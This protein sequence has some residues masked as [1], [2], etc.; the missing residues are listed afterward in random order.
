MPTA[1]KTALVVVALVVAYLAGGMS[2]STHLGSHFV[3]SYAMHPALL[4]VAL[5]L[6]AAVIGALVVR[7]LRQGGR[8]SSPTLSVAA[9]ILFT[10]TVS[11][12]VFGASRG[13]VAVASHLLPTQAAT[14]TLKVLSAGRSESRHTVCH[15]HLELQHGSTTERLCADMLPLQG[16]LRTGKPVKLIGVV[17]PLG[18][19]IH[20]LQVPGDDT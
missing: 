14:L 9:F 6:P 20:E 17:S 8:L 18:F 12:M 3:A 1:R 10:G 11:A 16:Q 19:H 4:I 7:G 13:W 2:I 15:Q 5:G